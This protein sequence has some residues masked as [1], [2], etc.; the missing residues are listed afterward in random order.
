VC[1]REAERWRLTN[2]SRCRDG[3]QERWTDARSVLILV[4]LEHEWP[5]LNRK[6]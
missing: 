4:V 3:E 6:E 2:S 5:E 1:G